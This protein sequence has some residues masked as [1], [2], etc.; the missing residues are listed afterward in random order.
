MSPSTYPAST[1]MSPSPS[2]SAAHTE[3]APSAVV[4]ISCSVHA[5]AVPPVWPP[6]RNTDTV[7]SFTDAAST[8]TAPSPSTSAA[9]TEAAPSAVVVS[10]CSDHVMTAPPVWPPLRN[11]DTVSPLRDATSTSSSPSPSTSAACT[12]RARIAVVVIVCSVHMMAAPPVWPPLKNTDTVSSVIDAAS[13][14]MSPSPSTSTTYT[15]AAPSAVVVISCS[16]HVMAA[17]PVWPPF[18]NTDTVSSKKDAANTSMSP[19]PSK[20]AAKTA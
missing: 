14:S 2:T 12:P 15:E 7:S 10:F 11:T 4:V 1:S 16:D 3:R 20:S 17:P 19:S 13:T 8:S 9:Y 18:R 6:L 5:M